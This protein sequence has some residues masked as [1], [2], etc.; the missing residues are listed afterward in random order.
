MRINHRIRVPEVR[1]VGPDGSNLGVL[2]TDEALRRAQEGGF[3]LVE[4]NPKASPPVCKILDFG[5][6]KYEEKKKQR[7]AKKKQAVVEVKEVKLRPK[8]DDHDLMVKVRA[9]RRFLEAG[10]KVKFTCR[11]RGREITHPEVAYQQF[12]EILGKLEDLTN[13]EQRPTMEGRAM[14]TIVSPKPQVL[15]RLAQERAQ[16]ERQAA[17]LAE[18]L[19]ASGKAPPPP[20]IEEEEED[21]ELHEADE[22]FDDE[23]DEEEDEDGDDD[24]AAEGEEK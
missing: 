5:K 24:E 19:A 8:T 6:F 4:V 1:V 11:F 21:E 2:P 7:E 16:R 14:A 10:N 23:D 13:V 15:Q 22:D 3:D 18:Q 17:K 12:N 20:T 9:A